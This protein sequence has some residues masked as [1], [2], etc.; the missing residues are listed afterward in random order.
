M[1]K[2]IRKVAFQMALFVVILIL[3]MPSSARA[4]EITFLCAGGLQWWVTEVIPE[5]KRATGYSVKPT[6]Q[7]INVIAERVRKGD[8]AD[9]ATVSLQQWDDLQ[10]EGKI[11]STIR[12][13]IAKLGFGVFVKKGA[14][15]PDISSVVAFK[16][17]F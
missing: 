16:H 17:A 14:A 6:F 15:K 4:T 10:K 5:F 8:T 3:A 12:V 2:A 9:L 7:V 11:D 13:V 1:C